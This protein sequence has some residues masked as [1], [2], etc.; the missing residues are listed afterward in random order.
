M[1]QNEVIQ[2]LYKTDIFSGLRP[3]DFRCLQGP[4]HERVFEDGALV[5]EEGRP[6]TFVYVIVDGEVTR[7]GPGPPSDAPTPHPDQGSLVGLTALSG[8]ARWSRLPEGQRTSAGH[9]DSPV[10][11]ETDASEGPGG[12][13]RGH[14]TGRLQAAYKGLKQATPE[15]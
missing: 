5:V 14:E 12:R 9:R 7:E 2:F 11:A 13:L 10:G 3:E 4:C 6:A 8:F 15:A 1:D